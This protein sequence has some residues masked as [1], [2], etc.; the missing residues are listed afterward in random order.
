ML[1]IPQHSYAV[2]C[3]L[4]KMKTSCIGIHSFSFHVFHQVSKHCSSIPFKSVVKVLP[5]IRIV[6][7]G[8]GMI[9]FYNVLN[10]FIVVL[11]HF[12]SNIIHLRLIPYHFCFSQN[13]VL[14]L[15]SPYRHQKPL[16]TPHRIYF[17]P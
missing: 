5:S 13:T 3:T 1:V 14:R 2:P 17:A 10:C 4:C 7:F 6:L 16:Q 11:P 15:Q 12:D 9:D 8:S